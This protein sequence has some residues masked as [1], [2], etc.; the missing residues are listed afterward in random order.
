MWP[1]WGGWAGAGLCLLSFHSRMW[2]PQCLQATS[3]CLRG[4][5][6]YNCWKQGK[7]RDLIICQ[8]DC[9][10][11]G[12]YLLSNC[13]E[14]TTHFHQDENENH[15][16]FEPCQ[17]GK[18]LSQPSQGRGRTSQPQNHTTDKTCSPLETH[19]GDPPEL[20]REI[21]GRLWRAILRPQK[22]GECGPG[23]YKL[24]TAGESPGGL[25]KVGVAHPT[26]TVLGLE[27]LPHP[28]PR[29]G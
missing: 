28:R 22:R 29:D 18:H 12:L 5:N 3:P 24:P 7:S 10:K 19:Q 1:G 11:L 25:V 9:H 17:T 23:S 21:W 8:V 26:P 2:P 14:N 13:I 15:N 16:S 4:E 6:Q 27:P 20:W